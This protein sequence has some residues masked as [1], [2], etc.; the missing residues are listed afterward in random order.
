MTAGPN[1]AQPQQEIIYRPEFLL[2]IS[3]RSA[4]S[5]TR[6]KMD[7]ESAKKQQG[8]KTHLRIAPALPWCPGACHC[9]TQVECLEGCVW[10]RAQCAQRVGHLHSTA[11]PTFS[12]AWLRGVCH[13]A[14]MGIVPHHKGIAK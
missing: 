9:S 8:K 6:D 14:P 1:L 3:E 13:C 5:T 12:E 10:G 4:L 11:A 7:Q 2:P